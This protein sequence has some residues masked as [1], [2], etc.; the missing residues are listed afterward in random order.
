[1]NWIRDVQPDYEGEVMGYSCYIT[2]LEIELTVSNEFDD[3]WKKKHWHWRME[4]L[5]EKYDSGYEKTS[6]K[7]KKQ[8][9]K[10]WKL[11][12]KKVSEAAEEKKHD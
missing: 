1:M 8:A 11:F 10:A 7:A 2:G 5:G 3:S 4:I 12:A 6:I 9:E